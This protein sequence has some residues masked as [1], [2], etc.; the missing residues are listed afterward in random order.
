MRR[1]AVVAG[2]LLAT[3]SCSSGDGEAATT[4]TTTRTASSTTEPELDLDA[5]H[6]SAATVIIEDETW[7]FEVSCAQPSEGQVLVWGSGQDPETGL[8]TELLLEASA[9]SPYVGV[10]GGG[11]LIEAALDGPLVLA[12]DAG[13][14]V[15]DDIVFVADA[16][17]DTG[18]GT[19]LGEGSVRVECTTYQQPPVIPD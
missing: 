9:A 1:T 3:A 11:R 7:E 15:G 5:L 10:T 8:P 14:I 19:P 17:I 2:L 16:D 18:V 12:I 13:T 4:T 6:E